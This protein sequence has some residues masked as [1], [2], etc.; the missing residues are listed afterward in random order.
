MCNVSR[1]LLGRPYPSSK[2]FPKLSY[3][4]KLVARA[5]FSSSKHFRA[6][7]QFRNQRIITRLVFS[8]VILATNF[9]TYISFGNGFEE[10]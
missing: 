10:G 5:G 7:N 4:L 1:R 9:E 8:F 2:T 3:V 6:R